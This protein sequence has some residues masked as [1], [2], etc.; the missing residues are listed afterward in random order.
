MDEKLREQFEVRKNEQNPCVFEIFLR[1]QKVY[2]WNDT[3]NKN[4]PEDLIWHREIGDLF[5]E[6]IGIGLYL[7]M[8]L[9]KESIVDEHKVKINEIS[10]GLA[11]IETLKESLR[12]EE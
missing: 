11:K 5:F 2:E 4:S 10:E 1:D 3:C 8:T 9:F 6:A 7:A 12:E